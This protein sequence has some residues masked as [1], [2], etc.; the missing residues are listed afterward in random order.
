MRPSA[1]PRRW[2]LHVRVPVVAAA[3]V[4]LV[5]AVLTHAFLRRL[6]D[7]QTHNLR[8]LVNLYVEELSSSVI[9]HVLHED[10]WEVYASLSRSLQANPGFGGPVL[11]VTN[12][13]GK[14]IASTQPERYRVD[15]PIPAETLRLL[16]PIDGLLLDLET[17]RALVNRPLVYQ[18][19]RIG[20]IYASLDVA[21]LLQGRWAIFQDMVPANSGVALFAA[22]LGYLAVSRMLG[23]VRIL[24]DHLRQGI[25]GTAQPIPPG[26]VQLQTEEF[27]R[28]FNRF[29]TM[30]SALGE[31][32]NI[33]ARLAAEERSSSLGR[34]ASSLA[35][36]INNPL[37]GLFNT[38]DTLRRHGSNPDARTNALDLLQ[39]GLGHIRDVVRA[40]LVVNRPD[41]ASLSLAPADLDDLR[42]LIEPEAIAK[43]ITLSWHN[44]VGSVLAL[45]AAQVRQ[46]VLNLLI[47]ACHATPPGGTVRL[48]ACV[49][50]RE[51]IVAI[52]DSGP[53]LPPEIAHRLTTLEQA[54][55]TSGGLGLWIV[56]RLIREAG[57]SVSVEAASGGSIIRTV[58]PQT[59]APDAP[60]ADSAELEVVSHA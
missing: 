28:L 15:A 35:H 5:S 31:R 29:N 54:T 33:A 32:E 41:E 60:A 57:G 4:L 2:S 45:P 3:F 30:V 38:L 40:A 8:S 14:I 19:R 7:V 16:G 50:A 53:G 20:N 44:D 49:Q 11:I 22:F 34:L 43:G 46:T 21:P 37:G 26:I 6:D 56:Q 27:R 13:A 52:G 59:C 39:R 1:D 51:L 12:G 58:W 18:G 24:S 47:N 42:L 48:H 55:P 36:E 10:V 25:A 17:A 9:P 23:P